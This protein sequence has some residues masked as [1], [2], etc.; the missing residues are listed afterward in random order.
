VVDGTGRPGAADELVADLTAAGLTTG[1]V[2][3]VEGGTAAVEGPA[4]DGGAAWLA[5]ALGLPELTRDGDVE[6]VTV[7][8]GPGTATDDRTADVLAAAEA[9]PDCTPVG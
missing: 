4:G 8:L 6:H 9:L 5:D 1:T 3:M 2:T 7:V